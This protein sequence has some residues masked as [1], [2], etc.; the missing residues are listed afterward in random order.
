ME[1]GGGEAR[2]VSR[3]GAEKPYKG[4]RMRKWGKWVAEIRE[5]NKRSRIWLGSYCT[6]VAAARAY[7]T[8]VYYLRGPSAK[9][10][11]PEEFTS[12]AGVK[13]LSANDIREMAVEVGSRV[14]AIQVNGGVVHMD[15]ARHSWFDLNKEPEPEDPNSENW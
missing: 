5:P 6:A 1:R 4:I 14:D 12:A 10:N 3:R 7:D 13:D 11:F 9:L 15:H 8:A 2:P